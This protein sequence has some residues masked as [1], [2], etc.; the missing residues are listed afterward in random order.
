MFGIQRTKKQSPKNRKPINAP[1]DPS[2]AMQSHIN[3][4]IGMMLRDIRRGQ[5]LSLADVEKQTEKVYKAS[6]LGAYER[7]ERAMTVE[8]L[9]N[10]LAF[11]NYYPHSFFW[12]LENWDRYDQAQEAS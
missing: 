10:L 3:R 12:R 7:A 6:V 2:P 5:G 1:F 8:R 9:F 11:Y 4:R